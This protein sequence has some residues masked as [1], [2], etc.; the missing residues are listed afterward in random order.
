MS[1][2]PLGYD[3]AVAES[4]DLRR[5]AQQAEQAADHYRTVADIR[6]EE[7]RLLRNH[8]S[9]VTGW[10][11]HWYVQHEIDGWHAHL[12]TYDPVHGVRDTPHVEPT[13]DAAWGWLEKAMEVL[14]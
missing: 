10:F 11:P 3:T 4:M 5:R 1:A 8:L 9:H 2:P 13:E 7:N 12:Q 14:G 6:D